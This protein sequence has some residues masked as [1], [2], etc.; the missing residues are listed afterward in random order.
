MKTKDIQSERFETRLTE[1]QKELFLQAAALGGYATL[2]AFIVSSAQERANEI[3]RNHE[4]LSF[5]E[6]DRKIF[7]DALLNPPQPN[8]RLRDAATRYRNLDI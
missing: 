8:E 2:S 5:A 6:S 7:V 3:I 1:A 4:L